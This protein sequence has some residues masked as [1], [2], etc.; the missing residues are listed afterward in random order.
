MYV[1]ELWRYPVKSLAGEPLS[2]AEIALDGIRGDRLVHVSGPHGVITSRSKPLLLGHRGTLGEDGELLIDGIPAAAPESLAAIREAAGPDAR[3]VA[4]DGVERFDILPLLVA[5]DGAIA[6]FGRDGRRLRSNIV[7]GDVEG[8]AERGW[9]GKA[10]EIGDVVIRLQSLRERCV[11]T[12]F[13]PDTIEQDADVL[14]D[15]RKRFEGTLALDAL[16][17]A[18]GTVRVGDTVTLVS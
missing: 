15:I 7:I 6:E 11:M 4:Y 2:E 3:L 9:E 8:L 10:L 18:P 13:D 17:G 14:R 5:T 16:V 1:K 12:T